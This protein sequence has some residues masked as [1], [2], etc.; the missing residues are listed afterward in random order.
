MRG[1]FWYKDKSHKERTGQT[2]QE[3]HQEHF[4]ETAIKYF[5]LALIKI[6]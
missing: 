3:F 4:N 5:T 1:S 6:N 2:G